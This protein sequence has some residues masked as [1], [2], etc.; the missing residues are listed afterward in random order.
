[1][2]LLAESRYLDDISRNILLYQHSFAVLQ[3]C[4]ASLNRLGIIELLT[5]LI[6]NACIGEGEVKVFSTKRWNCRNRADLIQST[7]HY[8]AQVVGPHQ[9]LYPL[10][11]TV[12][13]SLF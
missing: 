2:H 7:T 3:L 8:D 12:L 10:H 9:V 1:M 13:T 6:R 4:F 11:L 5:L